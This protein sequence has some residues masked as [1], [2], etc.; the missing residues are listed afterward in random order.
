MENT[1]IKKLY[2]L[3][4]FLSLVKVIRKHH[5]FFNSSENIIPYTSFEH[6]YSREEFRNP[7]LEMSWCCHI[8]RQHLNESHLELNLNNCLKP[9]LQNWTRS[10]KVALKKEY[11]VCKIQVFCKQHLNQKLRKRKNV[12]GKVKMA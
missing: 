10:S 3:W 2:I 4:W 5:Q 12:Y 9:W 7:R 6:T 1:E 11:T 8:S